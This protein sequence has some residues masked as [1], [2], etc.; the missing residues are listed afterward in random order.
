MY[1]EI[2][3]MKEV[4]VYFSRK[5]DNLYFTKALKLY[6][7]LDFIS[8]LER[9][10]PVSCDTYYKLP[11]G[12]IP[13]SVKDQLSLLRTEA[14]SSEREL[15][16]NGESNVFASIFDGIVELKKDIATGGFMVKPTDKLDDKYEHLSEYE[17]QLL[18]DLITQFKD[19]SVK[20][21]VNKTHEEHPFLQTS[22][23][24]VIDYKLAFHL[25]REDILP[26]RSY[27]YN[28]EVSQMQYYEGV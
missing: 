28:V 14:I 1:L 8:V 11:Y 5:I 16:E 20:D 21:I 25:N 17:K 26:N 2:D 19:I 27:K 10:K 23:N 7:Y 4:L 13:Q 12:P 9:G 24:N 22:S 6:Y 18:D 15:F 3:K